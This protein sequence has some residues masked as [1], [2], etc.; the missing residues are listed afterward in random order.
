MSDRIAELA[1][2]AL[3]LVLAGAVLVAPDLTLETRWAALGT[4]AAAFL[5]VARLS[6]RDGG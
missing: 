2:V 6:R 1:V 4:I 3:G 5:L